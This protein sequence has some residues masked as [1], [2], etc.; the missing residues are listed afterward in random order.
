VLWLGAWS[1]GVAAALRHG[2]AA[3]LALL[4]LGLLWPTQV[5]L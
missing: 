4:G 5:H 1:T 3:S 2:D